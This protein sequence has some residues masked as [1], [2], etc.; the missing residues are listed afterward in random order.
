MGRGDAGLFGQVEPQRIDKAVAEIVTEIDDLTIGDLAVGVG[1]LNVAFGVEAFGLL[2]VD[3]AV[4]LQGLS[5][6]VDLDIAHRGD[7]GIRVVVVDLV[8]AN[9]HL[10]I[11]SRPRRPFLRLRPR[12]EGEG[13]LSTR[14]LRIEARADR[15]HERK[16]DGDAA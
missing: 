11:R 16:Y 6:V 1:Q 5:R 3:D 13:L 15:R 2:I 10:L 12:W 4:R 9:E 14:A 8:R 7:A